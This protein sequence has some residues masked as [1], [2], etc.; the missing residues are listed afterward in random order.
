MLL[1]IIAVMLFVVNTSTYGQ[2][3][4]L[5]SITDGVTLDYN[6][7]STPQVKNDFA[8]NVDILQDVTGTQVTLQPNQTMNVSVGRYVIKTDKSTTFFI[9]FLLSG[10]ST[11]R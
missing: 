9:Y 5:S 10:V 4:N 3:F 1:A 2:T 8:A 7:G 6:A 11:N